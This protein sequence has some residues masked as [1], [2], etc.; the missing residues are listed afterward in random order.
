MREKK[1]ATGHHALTVFIP[2][3]V[4]IA[5]L[6][7]IVIINVVLINTN[8][9]RMS[10]VMEESANYISAMSDLQSGTS[11]LSETATTF[12][13]TSLNKNG[14]KLDV[15]HL[16]AYLSEYTSPKR[17]KDILAKFVNYSHGDYVKKAVEAACNNASK[18]IST[19]IRSLYL[20]KSVYGDEIPPQADYRIIGDYTLSDEELALSENDRLSLA[21]NLLYSSDYSINKHSKSIL[22]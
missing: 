4:L 14:E 22:P 1:E 8:S 5:I 20:V 2:T 21:L 15:S 9:K 18:M 6:H 3:M 12:C 19:Q 16:M 13:Y 17:P 7:V 11:M 10:Q